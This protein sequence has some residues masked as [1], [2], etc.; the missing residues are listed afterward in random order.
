[1]ACG[2]NAVTTWHVLHK[3]SYNELFNT[4]TNTY[5]THFLSISSLHNW[6]YDGT[7][8]PITY[9]VIAALQSIATALTA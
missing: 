2:L 6:Q 5:A 7:P 8:P 4:F 1:M 3:A 9:A